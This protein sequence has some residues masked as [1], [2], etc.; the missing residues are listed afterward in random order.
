[1]SVGKDK[2]EM[3]HFNGQEVVWIFFGGTVTDSEQQF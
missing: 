1:M 2:N 3:Y